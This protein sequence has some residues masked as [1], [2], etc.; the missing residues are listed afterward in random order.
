[1]LE[2]GV[3][4]LKGDLNDSS[5]QNTNLQVSVVELEN[6]LHKVDRDMSWVLSYGISKL[7][8]K[9]IV[10]SSFFEANC[11]LQNVCVD[12][13]RTTGCEMMKAEHNLRLNEVDIP[14]YDPTRVQKVE[15]EF[16]LYFVVINY[17]NMDFLWQM[18]S[19]YVHW[20]ALLNAGHL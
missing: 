4:K 5:L 7:V 17:L 12:F 14:L 8:D 1:M 15:E 20:W 18:L 9:L 11:D 3:Q 13:G 6:Q 2:H 16:L 19:N 10:E